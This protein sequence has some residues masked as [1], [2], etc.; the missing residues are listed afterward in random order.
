MPEGDIAM[1]AAG[2]RMV[3]RGGQWVPDAQAA[4]QGQPQA[5]GVIYGQRARPVPPQPVQAAPQGMAE[6]YRTTGLY[7][8]NTGTYTPPPATDSNDPNALYQAT[9]DRERA[10]KDIARIEGAAAGARDAGSM[11]ATAEQGRRYLDNGA[12]T[13]P[14]AEFRM[15][16]GRV[17]GG[18]LGILPGIPTTPETNALTGFNQIVSGLTLSNVGQLKGPLSDR[19]IK[20]LQGLTAS[21]DASPESNRR[22]IAGQ[23]WAAARLL[24]YEAAQTR[25][26]QELGRPSATNRAG[27][28]FDQWWANYAAQNIPPPTE[29]GPYTIKPRGRPAAPAATA[30]SAR[31]RAAR[32][33]RA[34]PAELAFY[35]RATSPA[36][37]T[38]RD[39]ANQAVRDR[40]AATRTRRDKPISEMTD[41]ELRALAEGR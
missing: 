9:F 34:T 12:P 13:G 20:F 38:R 24:A 40:S 3:L 33:E 25:W 14:A 35:E 23:E 28:S 1:N 15:G 39:Q 41:A 31:E 22:A 29:A 5:P 11:L 36:P 18:V 7:N 19:D 37:M 8:P 26:A 27:Q 4:P 16:A 17:A 21:I 2:E 10:K 30:P 32:R 6:A